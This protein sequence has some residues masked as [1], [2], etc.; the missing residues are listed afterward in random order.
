[1]DLLFLIYFAIARYLNLFLKLSFFIF[2]KCANYKSSKRN[3]RVYRDISWMKKNSIDSHG[4]IY[5]F[6]HSIFY[7]QLIYSYKISENLQESFELNKALNYPVWKESYW[8]RFDFWWQPNCHTYLKI[9]TFFAPR[10][11]FWL[12]SDEF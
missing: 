12:F 3:S 8:F 1:M 9:V 7:T 4:C 6:V 11:L 5:I 2:Y 10:K